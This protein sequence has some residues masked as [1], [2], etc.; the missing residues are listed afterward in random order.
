M[1]VE[2]SGCT[3]RLESSCLYDI[4]HEQQAVRQDEAGSLFT[5][6]KSQEALAISADD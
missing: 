4:V 3:R 2:G 5:V 1:S 6:L